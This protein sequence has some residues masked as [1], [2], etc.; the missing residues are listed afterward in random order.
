MTQA[1]ADAMRRVEAVLTRR[2]DLGLH[3]DAPATARWEG[4]TRVVSS[5]ANGARMATDMPTELGGTGDCVSPGWM[6]RAGIAACAATTLAMAAA[7]QGITLDLLEVDVRSKSDTR[8]LLAMTDERGARVPSAPCDVRLGVRIAARGMPKERL[9]RLVE[10][11]WTCSP[12]PSAV[13]NAVPIELH[14]EVA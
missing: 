6:F 1:I 7:A 13:V 12:I 8:G 10:E 4:G 14:V 3:D 9:R 5:H 2:P 11:S